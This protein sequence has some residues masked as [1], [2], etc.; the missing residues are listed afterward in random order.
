MLHELAPPAHQLLEL[1]GLESIFP[2]DLWNTAVVRDPL[3]YKF[4]KLVPDVD[5]VFN[6]TNKK[7][8]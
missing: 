6:S 1:E 4:E 3:V 8:I 7:V 2:V 5:Q